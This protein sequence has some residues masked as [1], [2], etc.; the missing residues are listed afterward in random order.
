MS[1]GL[2]REMEA[3]EGSFLFVFFRLQFTNSDLDASAGSDAVLACG[4]L[5]DED[6]LYGQV[7]Q[8]IV[9][10]KRTAKAAKL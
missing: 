7:L 10:N 3:D 5:F 4:G 9:F 1:R 6:G 2:L 8:A